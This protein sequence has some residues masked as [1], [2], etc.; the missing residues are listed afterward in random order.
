MQEKEEANEKIAI[1]KEEEGKGEEENNNNP[2]PLMALNHVSR[3]CRNL[4]ESKDFYAM[5]LGF[6][7]IERPHA[8]D[9]DGAWLFNYGV[10]VHLLQAKDED[11]LPDDPDHLD[12]KFPMIT[13]FHFRLIHI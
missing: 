2:P 12:P 11:R 10:G 7:L 9:F 5:V 3:L 6:V 8:F 13:I 4:K 1:K